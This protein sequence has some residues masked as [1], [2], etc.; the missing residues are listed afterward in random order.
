MKGISTDYHLAVVGAGISAAYTLIHYLE[1][2]RQHPPSRPVRN[3]VLEQAGEFWTGVP[4]GRRSGRNALI[5]TALREF[6]PEPERA[7]FVRWLDGNREKLFLPAEVDGCR[8]T[9]E[10]RQ[11][12]QDAMVAGRWDDL[13]LPRGLFGDYLQETMAAVLDDAV[14]DGLIGCTLVPRAVVDIESLDGRYQLTTAG[15]A[16]QV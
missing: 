2:L 13:F 15:D 11:H 12:N 10:W 4:Y 16:A 5:I 8:L 6:L 9:S 3:V 14:R 7:G 1:L